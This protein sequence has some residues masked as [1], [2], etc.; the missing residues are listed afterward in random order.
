MVTVDANAYVTLAELKASLQLTTET[1]ADDDLARAINASS[2][3]IDEWCG[4]FFYETSSQARTFTATS[5][6]KVYTDD[7]TAVTSLDTDDNGN[8]TY[9][10][11]WASGDYRLE[12]S[13]ADVDA[14]P[15]TRILAAP[16]QPRSFPAYRQ[17]VQVTGTFGWPSIPDLVVE[18]CRI[19]S[20]R[21]LKR[22]RDAPFGVAGVN[23]EGGGIRLLNRLD[24]DVE[25]M[26]KPLQKDP[27]RVSLG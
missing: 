1:F 25:L 14:E 12:P 10:V 11:A 8:G 17:G 6:A 13:N 27:V 2:R 7:I 22:T 23:F 24:A 9:G 18:A 3:L 21:L 5:P 4:R 15:Y 26:L 19:Q 20:S 16:L